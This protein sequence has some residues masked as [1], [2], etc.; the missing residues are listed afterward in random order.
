METI[1]DYNPTEGELKR[2]NL[3]NSKLIEEVKP[4]YNE[5]N[6]SRLYHLGLLFLMRKQSKKANYYFSQINDKRLLSTLIEDF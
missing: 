6:D 1:F 5:F 2:F 3:T 4:L